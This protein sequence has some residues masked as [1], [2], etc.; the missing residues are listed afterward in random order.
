M[1]AVTLHEW[2]S[3]TPESEPLLACCS[4]DEQARRLASRLTASDQL[5]TFELR[6]GLRIECTS[7]VGAVRLGELHVTI[8]PKLQGLPLL[9]L[10]RYA[11]GLRDLKLLE[12][13][14]QGAESTAFQDL[15]IHQL[16]AEVDELLSRGLH[17]TYGRHEAFLANPRGR[18]DFGALA[19]R[20]GAARPALPCS[21]YPRQEDIPLNRAVLAGLRHATGLTD[22]LSLRARLRRLSALLADG[23]APVSLSPALMRQVER[24][25]NRLTAAYRPALAIIQLLMT[26][27]GTAL[28]PYEG[29]PLPG[30]L[31]DMN[32]FFQALISRHLNEHLAGHAVRDEHRLE[33]M[34]AYDSRRNPRHRRAPVLR[35]DFV[36]QRDGKTVAM[37]D[38]KY[39]D[40]WEQTLPPAM[41]YQ[42]VMYASSSEAGGRAAIL[43]PT[44]DPAASDACIEV[45]EP[46]GGGRRAEVIL[47][48][49]DMLLL[50]RLLR[51][52][53]TLE[54]E[55]ALADH[56]RQVAYGAA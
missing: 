8:Q 6:D 42:L 9:T 22:D 43:Y 44:L 49:V 26:G 41:L 27:H 33:G 5:R 21:Y 56:A 51:G 30:F 55:R 2:C 52:P 47:R 24:H 29:L 32:R 50:E 1:N 25:A 34:L 28:R 19:R 11:Y 37:L 46:L 12:V 36:V 48:P 18:I 17:R 13:F 53:C 3:Y 20:A 40:L 35:P 38:A 39:R 31:F 7:F 23:V 15:L 45:H 16:G 10:V 54:S 14:P 4:L